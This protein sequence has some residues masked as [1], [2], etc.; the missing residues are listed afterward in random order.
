MDGTDI[1]KTAELEVM[2]EVGL[3][4]ACCRRHFLTHV[5]LIEKI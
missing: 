1:P 5:D 3:K 4:R 2:K